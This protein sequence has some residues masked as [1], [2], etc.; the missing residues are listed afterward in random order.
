[1]THP[2]HAADIVIGATMTAI[3]GVGATVQIITQFGNLLVMGLN[4]LLAI[5]GLYLLYLRIRKARKG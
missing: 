5:G 3:G 4:V 1:M 2:S